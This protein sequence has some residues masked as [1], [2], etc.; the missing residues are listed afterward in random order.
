MALLQP[1]FGDLSSHLIEEILFCWFK[2]FFPTKKKYLLLAMLERISDSSDES[3]FSLPPKYSIKYLPVNSKEAC[4]IITNL[5]NKSVV[6]QRLALMHLAL[7][8]FLSQKK[9]LSLKTSASFQQNSNRLV[10]EIAALA[11]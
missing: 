5:G 1:N 9:N 6:D 4:L 8:R 3:L 7:S 11:P 10:I 2:Y